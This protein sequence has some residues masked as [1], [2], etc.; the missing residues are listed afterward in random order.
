MMSGLTYAPLSKVK[1]RRFIMRSRH[2]NSLFM[3]QIQH[4]TEYLHTSTNKSLDQSV[5]FLQMKRNFVK[6]LT[7]ATKF[8]IV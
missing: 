1:K 3:D 6:K 5:H 4:A 7:F 8:L 2:Q